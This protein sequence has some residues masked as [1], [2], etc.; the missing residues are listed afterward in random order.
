MWL[1]VLGLI[2]EVILYARKIKYILGKGKVWHIEMQ[3][4][5][6]VLHLIILWIGKIRNK[7]TWTYKV[8]EGFFQEEPWERNSICNEVVLH[9]R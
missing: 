1:K 6:K 9:A 8:I 5:R 7:L 3:G 2:R 4:K